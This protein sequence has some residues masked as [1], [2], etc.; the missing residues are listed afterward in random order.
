LG[1]DDLQEGD[2]LRKLHRPPGDAVGPTALVGRPL[3]EVERFFTEKTLELAAG[4]REEAAKRLGI[5]E[6]TLYRMIQAWKLQDKIKQALADAKG[7]LADAAKQLGVKEQV[8]SRKVKKW[9][10]QA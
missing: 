8:L 2:E 5:G 6:R 10:L 1:L 7:N 4:N 9:G 3:S